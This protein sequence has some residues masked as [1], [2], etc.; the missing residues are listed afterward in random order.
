MWICGIKEMRMML[1]NMGL[2][3]PKICIDCVYCRTKD[4]KYFCLFGK[5][6]KNNYNDIILYTPDDYNC[7]NWEGDD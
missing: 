4:L 7:E 6:F 3:K 2:I 5:F 1:E